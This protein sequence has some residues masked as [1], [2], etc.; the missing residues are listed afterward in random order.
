MLELLRIFLLLLRDHGG[1]ILL[2]C[3]LI[4]LVLVVLPVFLELVLRATPHICGYIV[5]VGFGILVVGLALRVVG[6]GTLLGS[7]ALLYLQGLST[8]VGRLISLCFG[9]YLD[10]AYLIIVLIF[11]NLADS[12]PLYIL[13]LIG[14]LLIVVQ[15]ILLSLQLVLRNNILFHEW[16]SSY[17]VDN[18]VQVPIT[19]LEHF[20]QIQI[21]HFVDDVWIVRFGFE[22]N[23]HLLVLQNRQLCNRLL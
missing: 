15:S 22:R 16:R 8:F 9:V 3:L 21:I 6:G 5:L 14:L 7:G 11:L 19:L 12:V 10:L 20:L 17:F 23:L 18:E 13:V 1:I 4:L 2:G